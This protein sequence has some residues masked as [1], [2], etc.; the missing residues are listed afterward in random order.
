MGND[1]SGGTKGEE[2]QVGCTSSSSSPQVLQ[3]PTTSA[4]RSGALSPRQ[5]SVCSEPDAPYVS[6]TARRPIGESPQGTPVK[7]RGGR[8]ARSLPRARLT[9]S[10]HNTL[11]TVSR[12]EQAREGDRELARLQEIPT[13][14]PVMQEGGGDIQGRLDPAPLTT[15]LQRYEDHLRTCAT[16]VAAEQGNIN[17]QVRE[18][19]AVTGSLVSG[20][21]ERQRRFAGHAARLAGV[22]EV[23]RSLARCHMLLNENIDMMDALNNCLPAD[24]RLEPFVWTTG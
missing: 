10:V 2:V 4:L 5:G 24:L 8:L 14:L 1:Q 11:V 19:D 9:A 17:K 21:Q 16:L 6:Y 13:F 7:A 18:V 12:G 3:S 22:R 15:L 20:L 23:S